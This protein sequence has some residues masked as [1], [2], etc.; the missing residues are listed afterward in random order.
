MLLEGNVTPFSESCECVSSMT[1]GMASEGKFSFD[2][3]PALIS[4][5]SA[6]ASASVNSNTAGETGTSGLS[7]SLVLFDTSGFSVPNTLR[8]V[9]A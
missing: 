4:S 3:F 6:S 9:T 7:I 5:N 2:A 1:N 8:L